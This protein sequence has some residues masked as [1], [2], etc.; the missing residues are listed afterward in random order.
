MQTLE[1][2]VAAQFVADFLDV[3][4]PVVQNLVKVPKKGG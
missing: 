1:G 4:T 3:E 2:E